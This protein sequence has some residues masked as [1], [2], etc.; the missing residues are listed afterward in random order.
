LVRVLSSGPPPTEYVP[1]R[2]GFGAGTR[3]LAGR[4]NALRIVLA[5][6]SGAAEGAVQTLVLLAADVDDMDG[7]SLAGAA[8]A[9][10]AEG[11]LDVVLVPTVMKK[12]RP[13]TRL[14]VLCAPA[15]ARRLEDRVLQVT[16]SLGV[17]RT[18]VQR[19]AL[20][21]EMRVV[22]VHGHDVRVKVATLP[23]GA[24]RA[25]PE[26]DDLAAVA[27]ATGMPVLQIAAA[28]RRA[29]ELAMEGGVTQPASGALA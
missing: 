6:P 26:Y 24:W 27:A 17:R 15:S 3:E 14:E 11:A 12:G 1:L 28:A 9:L 25:K 8:D 4:A 13:G 16:T 7:E 29:A 19:R 10:R 22:R 21:R 20:A 2:S 5:E 23:D 18:E